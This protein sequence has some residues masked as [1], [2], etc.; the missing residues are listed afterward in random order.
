MVHWKDER[1]P[2][3]AAPRRRSAAEGERL[4][5]ELEAGGMSR[6]EFCQHHGL[7]LSTLARYQTRRRQAQRGDHSP[8][9]EVAVELASP[10]P[11]DRGLAVV[12]A[13]GRRVEVARGFDP[14]TLAQ[15]LGLLDRV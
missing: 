13:N 1:R 12:L 2:V 4:V 7:A 5:T 3:L 9:R 11:A 14:P 6:A 8:G 15:L 10:E